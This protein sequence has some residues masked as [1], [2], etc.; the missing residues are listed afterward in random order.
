MSHWS[1][2]EPLASA[3]PSFLTVPSLGLLDSLLLP[4]FKKILW[5]WIHRILP[6]H[7][8]QQLVVRVH[9]WVNQLKALDLDLGV[10]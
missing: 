2:S 7:S 6:L 4:S 9:I 10:S 8:V 5:C 3:T 1:S